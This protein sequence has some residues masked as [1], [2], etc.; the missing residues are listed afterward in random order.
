[1]SA[2]AIGASQRMN[3]I[4][5][6]QRHFYDLT[7]RPYLLGR[8]ALIRGLAPPPSGH[9]LEIG[10]GT[11]WNL[12]RA[13]DQYPVAHFYGLD[14]SHAMLETARQSVGHRGHSG[15]IKL[16][17]ADATSFNPT[18]LFGLYE[19]DRVFVSY[20]LSI[21]PD[22]PHVVARAMEALAPGGS[23]HIVDF[24]QCEQLPAAFRALLIAWLARFSVAPARDFEHEICGLA[25]SASFSVNIVR[26]YRGYAVRAVLTRPACKGYEPVTSPSCTPL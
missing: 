6:T 23:L 9:V 20:T 25:R 21:I 14:V 4:Y 18:E 16:A 13:A 12:I 24:G 2:A 15:R 19:F 8:T 17:H 5:C 11:A 1:M 7:R 10:C 26:L 3:R 22:W